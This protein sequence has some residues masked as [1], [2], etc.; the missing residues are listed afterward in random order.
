MAGNGKGQGA[1]NGNANGGNSHAG[2]GSAGNAAASNA[3]SNMPVDAPS[4]TVNGTPTPSVS[5]TP[6]NGNPSNGSGQNLSIQVAQTEGGGLTGSLDVL[7]N[8]PGSAKLFAVHSSQ[9]DGIGLLPASDTATI[10]VEHNGA[11]Y[12]GLVSINPDG[13]VQ[14]DLSSLAGN[15]VLAEGESLDVTFYYTAQMGRNG[16]LSTAAVTVTLTGED[17]PAEISGDDTGTVQEDGTLV[18]QGI[19][20]L[21]DPDAGQAVF[22]MPDTLAGMYGDFTFDPATGEWTYTL[23]NDDP[24]VQALNSGDAETDTLTITSLDG[25]SHDI[26]V[27]IE[28]ADELANGGFEE[29]LTGFQT[30]GSAQTLTTATV[31]LFTIAPTQGTQF[32]ALSTASAGDPLPTDAEIETFLGLDSGVLDA[33]GNGDATEGSA[34]QTS[35]F[36]K[37]GETLTFDYLLATEDAAPSN[38]FAF[39]T[40]TSTASVEDLADIELANT[41]GGSTDWQSFSFTATDAGTY[42]LGLGI[43]DTGSLDGTSTL[44][45]DWMLII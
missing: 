27:T 36:L 1:V 38:D 5:A 11:E 19:L 44:F 16:V 6:S 35:V 30:V 40:I 22:D 8:D 23:R 28:G 10:V 34:V 13:T 41:T 29:G 4:T 3:Q 9:P 43:V 18:A 32:L 24:L 12:E 20:T 33:A 45:I 42:D 26:V 17:R 14:V 7:A 37:A 15:L 39:L 25:T 2:N 31:G 21:A